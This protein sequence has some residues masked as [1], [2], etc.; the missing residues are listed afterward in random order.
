MNI[1]EKSQELAARYAKRVP[2]FR[3]Q[4]E[5]IAEGAK[6]PVLKVFG[7]WLEYSQECDNRDQSPVLGEFQQ[8]YASILTPTS[9]EA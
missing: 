1:D 7:L 4:L 5:R 6:L 2:E 9:S 8:W 3:A